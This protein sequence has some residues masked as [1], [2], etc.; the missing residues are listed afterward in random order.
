MTLFPS[1][2]VQQSCGLVL[3]ISSPP[4]LRLEKGTFRVRR[5]TTTGIGCFQGS[6]T[7][8]LENRRGI[9]GNPIV[10]KSV[11]I[12]RFH[13]RSRHRSPSILEPGEDSWKTRGSIRFSPLSSEEKFIG[14]RLS[15]TSSTSKISSISCSPYCFFLL[16]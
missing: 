9:P 5:E 2:R 14:F 1:S 8:L 15:K 10:R 7:S 6:T 3:S 11:L 13:H 16:L 12:Q 4:R